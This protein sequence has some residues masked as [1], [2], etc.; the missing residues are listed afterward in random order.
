MK[1]FGEQW[2]SQIRN[3]WLTKQPLKNGNRKVIYLVRKAID[4]ESYSWRGPDNP[5]V[6]YIGYAATVG[7]GIL[8]NMACVRVS[9]DLTFFS[10]WYP[11]KDQK[12][13]NKLQARLAKHMLAHTEPEFTF[14]DNKGF[15][16]RW[17]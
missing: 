7:K 14:R 10:D 1:T 2:E 8:P 15:D 4:T 3:K 9:Q 17:R 5:E 13:I 6:Y 16:G 12:I 11:Y